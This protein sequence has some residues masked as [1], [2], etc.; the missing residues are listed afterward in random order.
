MIFNA[1]IDFDAALNSHA[2]KTILTTT[3]DSAEY[4]A[5]GADI[6]QRSVI[7]SKV[8]SAGILDT[9]KG[10]V[11]DIL[12]GNTTTARARLILGSSANGLADLNEDRLNLMIE[13]NVQTAQGYGQAVAAND[14]D[15][16]D[17]FP[18]QEWFRLEDRKEPR[19][20]AARWMEAAQA[21]G[22]GYAAKA[23]VDGGRMAALKESG[24]WD[25]LGSIWDD[26]LGNNFP[27]FAFRSGMWVQDVS[28][29]EAVDLGLL[30][31]GEKAEP[32]KLPD[33]NAH[34][35]F[36]LAQLSADVQTALLKNLGDAVQFKDGVLT[37]K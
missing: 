29:E 6:L 11:M 27:P 18:A 37:L 21:A 23:L 30:D 25:Q 10:A 36:S 5:L 34:L 22:D 3:L 16:I 35:K 7:S 8:A 24:I 17:A 19:A 15:V 4:R 33:F 9:L 20:G 28:Y 1:P 32:M 13:T 26:S 14:P 31:K 12:A 2:V